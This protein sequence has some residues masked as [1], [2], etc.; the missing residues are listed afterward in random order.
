MMVLV[1]VFGGNTVS[2]GVW[3]DSQDADIDADINIFVDPS[4]ML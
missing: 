4:G 3:R 1:M 2:F